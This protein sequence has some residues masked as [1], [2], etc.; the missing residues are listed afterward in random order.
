MSKGRSKRIS[1]DAGKLEPTKAVITDTLTAFRQIKRRHRNLF[2][3]GPDQF[4]RLLRKCEG[5]VFNRKR[6]PKDDPIIASA[7]WEV[8]NGDSIEVAFSKRFP[9]HLKTLNEDLYT[10]AL[11]N[12]DR[13]VKRYIR[14]RP[15]SKRLQ[16]RRKKLDREPATNHS[17][18]PTV[19]KSSG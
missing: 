13:K 18:N 15:H 19:P 3:S 11:G 9:E 6:G 7:A 4:R 14:R 1:T 2:E 5:R 10:M 16:S 8:A 12:F 17:T